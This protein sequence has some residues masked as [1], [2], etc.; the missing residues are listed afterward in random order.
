MVG[1]LFSNRPRVT[2][3]NCKTSCFACTDFSVDDFASFTGVLCGVL[4]VALGLLGAG[5]VGGCG[6]VSLG[7]GSSNGIISA[8]SKASVGVGSGSI[9]ILGGI[10]CGCSQTGSFAGALL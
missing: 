6:A 4:T 8:G 5:S 10:S 2:A 7:A 3:S 1:S 9:S